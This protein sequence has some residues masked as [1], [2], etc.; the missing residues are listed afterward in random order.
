MAIIPVSANREKV[1]GN[2][3]GTGV[4]LLIHS[5]SPTQLKLHSA[6]S[7]RLSTKAALV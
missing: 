4:G 6:A 7:K 1:T 3:L 5:P 2:P